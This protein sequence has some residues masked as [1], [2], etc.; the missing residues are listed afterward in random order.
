M[1]Q[2]VEAKH[3]TIRKKK[4]QS[5]SYNVI[6]TCTDELLIFDVKNIATKTQQI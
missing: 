1:P 5:C 3:F 4:K 2:E 6:L